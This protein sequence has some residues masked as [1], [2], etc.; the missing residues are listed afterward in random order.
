M[1]WISWAADIIGTLGGLFAFFAWVQVSLIRKELEREKSRQSETV[2]VI[3][4]NP[5]KSLELPMELRRAEVTRA[6]VLGRLGMIP[7]KKRSSRFEIIYLNTPDFLRQ[8]NQIREGSGAV[9]LFIEC[10]KAEID[11]FQ[12]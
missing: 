6:E 2:K 4:R 11:Q 12:V 3:L 9:S 1:Q 10:S 7:M 5:E 8:I